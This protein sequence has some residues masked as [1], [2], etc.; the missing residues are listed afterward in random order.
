MKD[1]TMRKRAKEFA[2]KMISVCDK[3][4]LKMS[5]GVLVK[6]VI[7]SA[8]SIGANLQES[9][10]AVSKADFINKLQIS[11]KECAETE[12]W[13][14]LLQETHAISQEDAKALQHEAGVIHRM[15]LNSLKKLKEE[16]I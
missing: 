6:Q 13:L 4:E 3:I 9:V 5:R 8:T 16:H 7:R 10:Y 11:L 2:L 15:L 12:Y 1:S 14:E